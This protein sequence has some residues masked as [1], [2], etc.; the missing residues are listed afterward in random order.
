[1]EAICSKKNICSIA[2]FETGVD[3]VSETLMTEGLGGF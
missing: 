3:C 1:M 2:G